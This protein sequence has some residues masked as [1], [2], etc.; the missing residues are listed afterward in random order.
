MLAAGLLFVP[1]SFLLAGCDTAETLPPLAP[2]KGKVT[3]DGAPLTAGHVALHPE[4]PDASSKV[5]LSAGV[6]DSSGNY[7]IF[8]GGKPGAP[9]MKYKVVVAPSM[10]P[11]QGGGG[12][13]SVPPKYMSEA[14]TPLSVEVVQTPKDGQYDLQLSK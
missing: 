4:K 13:P 3:L 2:V 11:V 9:L 5:P 12:P 6:V 8:T 14:G 1:L 10:V 7:E